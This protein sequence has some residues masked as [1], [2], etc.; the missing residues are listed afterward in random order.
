MRVSA[1]DKDDYSSP[2]VIV[3]GVPNRYGPASF[4]SRYTYELL[5]IFTLYSGCFTDYLARNSKA[6]SPR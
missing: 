3:F 2:F 5:Q 6:Y 4:I 1:G